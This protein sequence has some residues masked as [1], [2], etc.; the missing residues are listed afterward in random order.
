MHLDLNSRGVVITESSTWTFDGNGRYRRTPNTERPVAASL[1]GALDD[2]QWVAWEAAGFILDDD[3]LRLRVLPAGRPAG[4]VGIFTGV[5][6]WTNLPTASLVADTHFGPASAWFPPSPVPAD[7]DLWP[8]ELPFTAFGQ[9]GPGSLDLRV[10]DQDVYW[11]DVT[12]RAHRIDEMDASYLDNVIAMLDARA[13][14]FHCSTVQ[15]E[16]IQSFGDVML[17]RT[18]AS[19]LINDLGIGAV[20]DSDART[21]LMSTP[22]MRALRARVA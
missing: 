9:F 8:G 13:V 18:P 5:V 6:R 15:R 2:W 10:F 14:E 3:C 21:W 19:L 1:D 11:V 16:A 4:S 17:G 20:A 12:G 22:L 7:R